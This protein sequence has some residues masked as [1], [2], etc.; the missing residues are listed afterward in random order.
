MK[1]TA[2]QTIPLEVP[3]LEG[4][5]PHLRRG[6]QRQEDP[7]VQTTVY[8][9]DTDEGLTGF[10]EG[11]D[12]GSQ[13]EAYIGHS[14]FEFA[15]DDRAGPLQIALYDL[16]GKFAGQPVCHL[17]GPQVRDQV[18]I[19]YWSHCFAPDILAT[20]ARLALSSGFRF[21]KIKAR[22]FEDT[23]D[24]IAA[25]AAVAPPDYRIMVDANGTYRRPTDALRIAR[26]L[27]A[28]PQVWALETP[29]PQDQIEGYKFLKSHL[30]YPIAI[31]SNTPPVLRA[32]EEGMCD[33]FVS[34][35][36]WSAK[37]VQDCAVARAAEGREFWVENG[38]LS[39]ISHA[40]QLHQAAAIPN[41]RLLITL[42]FLM[43]DDLI[44]EPMQVEN[45]TM[46]VPRAP[47]LGVTLDL[48][49]VEH[50]RRGKGTQV[51]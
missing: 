34:E 36:D 33:Y 30:D 18:T 20:E 7:T 51:G 27:Q 42:A 35:F 14:P 12:L 17:F 1:I 9:V 11:P 47:G 19:A 3:Y 4:V 10:G 45:G 38:L 22:P 6:W 37:L 26:Q 39:G 49:A 48:D 29:I 41:I 50:Y 44:A 40:F 5:R 43:E 32:V 8:I 24:Q 21:H 23:A 15:L 31:H 13:V 28:H 16:M 2:I 46:G 25:M